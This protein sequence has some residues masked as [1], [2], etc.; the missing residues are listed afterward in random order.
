MGVCLL[1]EQINIYANYEVVQNR[2]IYIYIY[3]YMKLNGY[4]MA[5]ELPVACSLLKTPAFVEISIVQA[6]FRTV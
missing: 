4:D 2:N 5:C 1:F 3:I 6:L